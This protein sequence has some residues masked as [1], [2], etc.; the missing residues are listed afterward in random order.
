MITTASTGTTF[1]PTII[2][3]FRSWWFDPLIASLS[4]FTSIMIY[5]YHELKEKKSCYKNWSEFL[6]GKGVDPNDARPSLNMSLF[7]YWIGVSMWVNVVPPPSSCASSYST[8][9][10]DHPSNIPVPDG[11]PNLFSLQSIGYLLL[12]VSSGI[13]LYDTIFFFVHLAVHEC[14]FIGSITKHYEH[15]KAMKYLEARHVLRH[16]F[17]DGM[18]QVLVNIIVQRYTFWGNVKSRFARM[19]HNIIVT[20]M[21]TES[22]SASEYPNLFKWWCVGVREHRNH[23]L[24]NNHYYF[25]H[26][27]KNDDEDGGKKQRMIGRG[28]SHH[29]QQF[30]GHW[31]HLW[32]LYLEQNQKKKVP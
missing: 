4:F 18:L 24:G 14:K 8:C 28:H 7:A 11:I 15:H 32:D 31:D 2:T 6:W 3:I 25:G 5:S 12:E 9:D 22:H 16:S 23:H 30:F 1:T 10:M 21:L 17:L 20:M 19:L 26:H 27:Y 29:F 13:I